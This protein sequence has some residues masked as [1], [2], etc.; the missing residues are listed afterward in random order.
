M[1]IMYRY[2]C[3]SISVRLSIVLETS[4]SP[5]TLVILFCPTPPFSCLLPHLPSPHFALQTAN[6]RSW[7]IRR[8][9]N[10]PKIGL[11]FGRRRRG[12]G[13]LGFGTLGDVE[14]TTGQAERT[15]D[16]TWAIPVP[17]WLVDAPAACITH[18][19]AFLLVTM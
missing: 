11:T 6:S 13:V 19:Q 8:V 14:R 1:R 7:P 15:A 10:V 3:L 9:Y 17:S 18:G 4:V 5:I 2:L 16:T 12:A